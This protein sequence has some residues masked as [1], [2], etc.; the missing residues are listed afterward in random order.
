MN[1]QL[2]VVLLRAAWAF[3]FVAGLAH[4]S[5]IV[6]AQTVDPVTISPKPQ[7]CTDPNCEAL[8]IR[9]LVNSHGV[10]ANPWVGLFNGGQLCLRFEVESQGDDL[11]MSVVA[12]DGT[13]FTDDDSG[14]CANSTN[15]CPRVIIANVT[16]KGA[17]TTILSTFDGKPTEANFVLRVGRYR[18]AS[19]PNCIP[20]TTPAAPT[21]AETRAKRAAGKQ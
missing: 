13:V 17:Y 19:N 3:A 2:F 18:P 5:S 21:A 20:A 15:R 10:V 12:P 4:G 7:K 1:S 6:R 9:G 8:E 14:S 16:D 11:A